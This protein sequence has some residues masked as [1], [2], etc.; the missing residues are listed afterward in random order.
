MTSDTS[1]PSRAG[2][3]R[4]G[5]LLGVV[6]LL[7]MLGG[8]AT[9]GGY[10]YPS[11][12]QYP[13]GSYPD[14]SY[15]DQRYPDDRYGSQLTGTV[16]GVDINGR[17]LILVTQTSAYARGARV[18]VFFD[19]NTRL[20]YQGQVQPIQGLERGDVVRVE[21]V[22]SSGRIWARTIEVVRNVR[23]GQGGGTYGN[24]LRGTVGY[25]DTRNRVI[26]LDRGGYGGSYGSAG[27]RIRYDSRT[28]VEYQGRQYRPENLDR[29]DLVRI[30][31]RQVS[32]NE[33]LAERIFVE[34]SAR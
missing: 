11:S 22:Q 1:F 23:E 2:R 27:G 32:S 29:G 8:C 19:Q 24:E 16:E 18:E 21:T 6:A 31:A 34:R 13:S 17:R 4:L 28:V 15:P 25:V 14:Q 5:R 26:E 12:G 20:Y 9:G 7:L 10:G 30:Q 3:G 33:W